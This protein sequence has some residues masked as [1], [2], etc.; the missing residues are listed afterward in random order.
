MVVDESVGDVC[1][2]VVG[3]GVGDVGDGVVGDGVGDVGDGVVGD[4]VRDVGDGVVGDRVGDVGGVE[5]DGIG[6]VGDGVVG[7]GIGDVSAGVVRGGVGDIGDGV[8]LMA[9]AFM[10]ATASGTASVSRLAMESAGVGDSVGEGGDS[11]GRSETEFAI[12]PAAASHNK[13]AKGADM[14]R[15]GSEMLGTSAAVSWAVA[16]ATSAPES[17][18]K[19]LE[20]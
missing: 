16:S 11:F 19:A 15:G 18:G 10:L 12:V 3:D 17:S 8:V 4:G 6:D 2:G 14:V 9:L 1:D 20:T 13:S 5:G 7:D